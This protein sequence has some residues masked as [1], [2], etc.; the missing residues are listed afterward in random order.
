M[1]FCSRGI[2]GIGQG[3]GRA[4]IFV[5][6]FLHQDANWGNNTASQAKKG[7]GG[8]RFWHP[9]GEEREREIVEGTG[10]GFASMFFFD[11][12][13]TCINL[14]IS[15]QHDGLLKL[16]VKSAQAEI[17]TVTQKKKRLVG[18]SVQ[19]SLRRSNE[20]LWE[21]TTTRPIYLTG[22]RRMEA[23]RGTEKSRLFSFVLFCP[24]V[25][26]HC[27]IFVSVFS[28]QFLLPPP[29]PPHAIFSGR[30][31]PFPLPPPSL[32]ERP[33][34]HGFWV[35]WLGRRRSNHRHHLENKR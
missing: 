3:G 12:G 25:H 10:M 27:S 33:P 20:P 34:K 14:S 32:Q 4:Q 28:R 7:G 6:F 13:E 30:L 21:I 17:V 23:V 22:T 16:P 18:W 1:A 29:P 26:R 5:L 11:D 24:L 8:E 15:V 2:C 31:T 9:G 19:Y 35:G